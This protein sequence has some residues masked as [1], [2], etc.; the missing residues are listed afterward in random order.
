MGVQAF[1][2]IGFA[3][4]L[5]ALSAAQQRQGAVKNLKL[6]SEWKDLEYAFPTPIA[7]QAAIQNNLYVPGNGV[8]IDM[9]V[10]YREQGASRIFVTIPRFTT[11]IPVTFGVLSNTAGAGG[12]IIQ[13]YPDYNWHSSHGQNCDGLTSVFRVTVR[14]SSSSASFW[15]LE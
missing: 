5:I 12:P 2:L 13:P 4:V 6:V 3:A 1:R 9:D 15:R 8:P 7:R 10:D 11:G 14:N